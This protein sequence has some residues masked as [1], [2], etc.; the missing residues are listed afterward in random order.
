MPQSGR[1]DIGILYK[2]NQKSIPL[3]SPKPVFVRS[4]FINVEESEDNLGIANFIDDQLVLISAKG[5][6]AELIFVDA[7]QY[8]EGCKVSGT[9]KSPHLP[10]NK[11]HNCPQMPSQNTHQSPQMPPKKSY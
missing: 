8:P 2:E 1:F 5:A 10:P 11:P 9:H 7:I 3:S 6:E 4:S